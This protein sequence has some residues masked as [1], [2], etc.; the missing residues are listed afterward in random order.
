MNICYLHLGTNM[1][2]QTS[3]IKEAIVHIDTEI[4]EVVASS[5]LYLTEPWG[6]KDQE[7]FTNIAIGVEVYDSPLAVL[8]KC[9]KIEDR[10]GRKREEK[11]GRRIIDIDLIL[12]G[13]LTSDTKELTLPHRWMAERRF[14]LEPMAEIAGD[15]VHPLLDK[16]IKTLLEE[17]DDEGVVLKVTEK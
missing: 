16:S 9:Q 3:N 8:R 13:D 1:G 5:S 11:W 6:K 2:D 15:V 10:M 17:C 7:L 4:G 14:V 12:M